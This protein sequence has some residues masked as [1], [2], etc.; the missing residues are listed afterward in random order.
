VERAEPARLRGVRGDGLGTPRILQRSGVECEQRLFVDPVLCVAARWPGARQDR[1]LSMPFFVRR[2][3]AIIA[4]YFDYLSYFFDRRWRHG[5]GDI[6]SLMIKLAD[7]GTGSVEGR[8]ID[9]TLTTA[10]RE[11]LNEA[12]ELCAEI[13]A[14]LVSRR[15][16][17][18]AARRCSRPHLQLAGRSGFRALA[19]GPPGAG[20]PTPTLGNASGGHPVDPRSDSCVC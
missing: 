17:R 1:E 18:A 9:T 8:R 16:P 20:S 3:A 12:V 6:F 15:P 14:R 10:D 2:D 11:R 5:A 4:P 19:P 7:S 13:F